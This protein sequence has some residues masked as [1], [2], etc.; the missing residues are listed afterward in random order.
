[1][2]ISRAVE[3]SNNQKAPQPEVII[4]IDVNA[5]FNQIIINDFEALFIVKDLSM[6]D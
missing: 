6:F 4:K 5:L 1:M 3:I 2:N